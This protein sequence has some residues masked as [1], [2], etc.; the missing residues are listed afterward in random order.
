MQK[1]LILFLLLFGIAT[2]Q[3]LKGQNRLIPGHSDYRFYIKF[4]AD[5]FVDVEN[6]V[7][8]SWGRTR[9][10]LP[11]LTTIIP[12]ATFKQVFHYSNSEKQRIQSRDRTRSDNRKFDKI[13]FSGLVELVNAHRHFSGEQLLALA[14]QLEAY[15]IV[16]YCELRSLTP[17]P[18]PS[19]DYTAQQF[20][21]EGNHGNDTIGINMEY[22]W[23]QGITGQGV[24]IADVEWGWDYSHEDLVNQ[25]LVDG[26][27]TT[28]TSNNN[29]GTAVAGI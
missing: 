12:Q 29:H 25:P 24:S 21:K 11:D 2:S 20:Y 26:L 4:R 16:E 5:A 8:T 22:A 1:A 13:S 15:D 17:P 6:G 14:Q 7:V 28:N 18:P 23:A 19:L 3:N 9:D 10:A 27:T